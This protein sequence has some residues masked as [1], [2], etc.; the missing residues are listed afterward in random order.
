MG[1]AFRGRRGRFRKGCSAVFSPSG[2]QGVAANDRTNG[3]TLIMLSGADLGGYDLARASLGRAREAP[4]HCQ[5][6]AGRARS[7]HLLHQRLQ[8]QIHVVAHHRLDRDVQ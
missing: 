1:M 7:A 4:P 8:S 6:E 5:A 3:H 2:K